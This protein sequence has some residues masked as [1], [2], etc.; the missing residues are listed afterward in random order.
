MKKG[1]LVFFGTAVILMILGWF[2]YDKITD[3]AYEGM[4]I[5]PEQQ[6]DIP[7]YGGLKASRSQYEIEGDRWED[8]YSF[9]LQELPKHGWK[10]EYIQ[11]A[12]DDEDEENDW[13]GFYSLWRKEGFEGELKISSHYQSFEEKTEV[14]FDKYPVIIT[15][16]WVKDT[17]ANICIYATL[18]D[19]NCSKIID[20]SKI[21]EI[22]SLINNAIDR[23]KEDQ[24]PNRK[25]A[26]IIDFGGM[27]IKV[28]YESDKEIYFLSEKGWKVM[29][30]EPTFFELTN[31]TP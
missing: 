22:Q 31:L 3:D 9:Y 19:S 21:I 28:Y 26:S 23:E 30:P 27:E 13:S 20:K 10:V 7:L 1:N 16:P 14:S 18:E 15:T 11:S 24:L 4:T 8:I 25:K 6:K 17:P 2:S 5:I 29:K 12:L